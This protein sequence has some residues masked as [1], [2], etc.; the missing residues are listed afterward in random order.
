MGETCFKDKASRQGD[1][2]QKV[3]T[4]FIE[5]AF[6]LLDIQTFLHM[7]RDEF[8]SELTSQHT[9]DRAL[10]VSMSLGLFSELDCADGARSAL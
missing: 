3:I 1:S 8:V 2:V 7:L 4:S 9:P 6:I 10:G 5:M